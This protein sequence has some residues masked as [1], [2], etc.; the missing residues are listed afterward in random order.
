MNETEAILEET[1]AKNISNQI[2]GIKPLIQEAEQIPGRRNTKKFIPGLEHSNTTENK[3]QRE[4]FKEVRG[5]KKRYI[6]FE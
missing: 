2:K 4:K 5:K 1:L 3:R 6:A